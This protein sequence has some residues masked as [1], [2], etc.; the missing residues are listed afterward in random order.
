LSGKYEIKVE[1]D[2]SL[3]IDR[4][5]RYFV[6]VLNYMRMGNDVALPNDREG[7]VSVLREAQYYK[8]AGL[9]ELVARALN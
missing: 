1:N 6:Y 4:D 8:L 9:E 3:Y 5:G 2:G 7:L